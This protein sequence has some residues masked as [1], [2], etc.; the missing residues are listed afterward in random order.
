MSQLTVLL[1]GHKVDTFAGCSDID[2]ETADIVQRCVVH[3]AAALVHRTAALDIDLDRDL[4]RGAT[5]KFVIT[6]SCRIERSSRVY[7]HIK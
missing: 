3:R 1:L 7:T 4:K 5:C 6:R 2:S